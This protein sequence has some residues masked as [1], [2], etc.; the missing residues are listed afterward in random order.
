MIRSALFLSC[1]AAAA[2]GCADPDPTG[3]QEEEL[4]ACHNATLPDRTLGETPLLPPSALEVVADLQYPPGNMAVSAPL[5]E[6]SKARIFFSYHPTANKSSTKVAEWIDGASVAYPS[7]DFQKKLGSVL[8]VRVDDQHRLW[9]LDYGDALGIA[10]PHLYAVD[11]ATNEIVVDYAFPS[12][13]APLGSN[14][15]DLQVSADGKTVF[16]ADTSI[17]GQSQAIVVVDFDR[18]YPIARRRL[19]K[20]ASVRDGAYDLVVNGNKVAFAGILCP[21]FGVDGIAL[22][23]TGEYLYY[24]AV[25]G[26]VLYR[27]RTFDLRYEK[28]GL[29]DDALGQ[30]V[31]KVADI[32]ATDGMT[33]D[34]EGH[35]YLSDPEHS[36]LVRV[37]LDGTLRVLVRDDRLRWPDGFSWG[38]DGYLYITAS[39]LQEASGAAPKKPP[40]QIFRIRPEAACSD[41]ELCRGRPGH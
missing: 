26:G 12:E 17:I 20:H 1:A 33:T 2:L 35:V 3:Q 10:R 31:E 32:T 36:A 13:S 14:F 6:G 24:S 25:N 34:A 21:H 40:Y 37:D 27:A 15:N 16:V 29:L 22:D 9:M 23:A 11:L 38:E 30:R 4:I 19:R 39:A 5:S 41:Q 18:E 8:G 7:K 28:S